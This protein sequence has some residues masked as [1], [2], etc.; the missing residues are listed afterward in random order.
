MK[1]QSN[2]LQ[3]F[4]TTHESLDKNSGNLQGIEKEITDLTSW[5]TVL[6]RQEKYSIPFYSNFEI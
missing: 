4:I 3:D 6:D 2:L 5:P 1:N